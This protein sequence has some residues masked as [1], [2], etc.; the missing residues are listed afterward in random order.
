PFPHR[1][2]RPE[3]LV[4][5]HDLGQGV[6]QQ[7]GVEGERDVD[8]EDVGVEGRGRQ[9]PLVGPYPLLGQGER[10]RRTGG[11]PPYV[12][13]RRFGTCHLAARPTFQERLLRRR[14]R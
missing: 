9:Q 4:A 11:P 14:E 6:L 13:A 8:R 2:A 12:Q 5:A 10:R 7:A 1:V 3:R